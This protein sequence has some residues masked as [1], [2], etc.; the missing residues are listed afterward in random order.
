M[1]HS[2]NSIAT[3]PMTI[4][5]MSLLL[6]ASPYTENFPTYLSQAR[7]L[8]NTTNCTTKYLVDPRLRAFPIAHTGPRF[9][10]CTDPVQSITWPAHQAAVDVHHSSERQI[11]Y[12]TQKLLVGHP[13]LLVLFPAPGSSCSPGLIVSTLERGN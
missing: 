4:S 5:Y 7:R 12:T 2:R 6:L 1:N 3:S 9:P 8:W 10:T 11:Y 13:L